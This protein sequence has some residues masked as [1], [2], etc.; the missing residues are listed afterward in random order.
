MSSNRSNVLVN[1]QS[2]VE[3]ATDM[4]NLKVRIEEIKLDKHYKNDNAQLYHT[5]VCAYLSN[6]EIRIYESLFDELRV[7]DFLK[8]EQVKPLTAGPA[9]WIFPIADKGI[10]VGP[11]KPGVFDSPFEVS[12]K[13]VKM[14]GGVPSYYSNNVVHA[15]YDTIG[16]TFI[17]QRAPA[18]VKDAIQIVSSLIVFSDGVFVPRTFTKKSGISAFDSY[19]VKA[20]SI[21]SLMADFKERPVDMSKK[22]QSTKASGEILLRWLDQVVCSY[23]A[24]PEKVIAGLTTLKGKHLKREI[25]IDKEVLFAYRVMKIFCKQVAPFLVEE[26]KDDYALSLKAAFILPTP[27]MK[28]LQGGMDFTAFNFATS[29]SYLNFTRI[30]R[31]QDENTMGEVNKTF[32]TGYFLPKSY[33]DSMRIVQEVFIP[34]VDILSHAQ[35]EYKY[36]NFKVGGTNDLNYL[37]SMFT[38]A[39][40]SEYFGVLSKFTWV[41]QPI[42]MHNDQHKLAC[43]KV[44][45]RYNE[46]CEQA[47][48][49]HWLDQPYTFATDRAITGTTNYEDDIR[50]QFSLHGDAPKIIMSVPVHPKV[51][52]WYYPTPCVHNIRAVWTNLDISRLENVVQFES[53][54]KASVLVNWF[55]T[56]FLNYHKNM[57]DLIE[58]MEEPPKKFAEYEDCASYLTPISSKFGPLLLR[59]QVNTVEEYYNLNY[60]VYKPADEELETETQG[61]LLQGYKSDQD[62][63]ESGSGDEESEEPKSEEADEEVESKEEVSEPDEV[64]K[65][66]KP[67]EKQVSPP[68]KKRVTNFH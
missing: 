60:S 22:D 45:V 41:V 59:K 54:Y 35:P 56:N 26:K 47:I 49:V 34:L 14:I 3:N 8:V 21:S 40:N 46:V 57:F 52:G 24:K 39:Q 61:D 28:I 23:G 11:Q 51:G 65:V 58:M 68:K 31:G 27:P 5:S 12:G 67:I 30:I 50:S 6:M 64:V 55:R 15:A 2:A 32:Y 44:G 4:N 18:A 25:T 48:T 38:L 29:M 1:L 7:E 13:E 62:D 16:A 19:T 42:G 17:S 37:L 53:Y 20:Q 33:V 63:D 66:E 9:T 10:D 36:L 43:Q